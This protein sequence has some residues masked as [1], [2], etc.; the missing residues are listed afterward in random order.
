MLGGQTQ[1]NQTGQQMRPPVLFVYT[2]QTGLSIAGRV[3]ARQYR[4]NKPGDLQPVDYR[5]AAFMTAVPVLQR[6]Q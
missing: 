2:G 5:D 4:F 1:A 6:I 3:T